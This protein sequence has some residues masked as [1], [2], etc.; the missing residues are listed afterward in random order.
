M[1]S[2][3][4][5]FVENEAKN[6][7]SKFISAHVPTQGVS[8][9]PELGLELLLVVFCR[10]VLLTRTNYG[11]IVFVSPACLLDDNHLRFN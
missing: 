5:I 3:R 9:V 10:Q 7:V 4:Q 1:H 11:T 2:F 6:V 8:D